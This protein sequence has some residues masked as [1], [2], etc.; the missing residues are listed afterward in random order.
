MTL[1]AIYNDYIESKS[2]LL[3]PHTV[4]SYISAYEKHI[5]P[6]LAHRDIESIHYID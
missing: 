2:I 1:D 6:L 5:M 3:D 4:K